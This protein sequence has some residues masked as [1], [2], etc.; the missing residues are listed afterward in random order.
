MPAD[1]TMVLLR[2]ETAEAPAAPEKASRSPR[3]PYTE[4]ASPNPVTNEKGELS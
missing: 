3:R 1:A 2:A 4:A